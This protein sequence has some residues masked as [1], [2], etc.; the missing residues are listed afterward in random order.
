MT[1]DQK[2]REAAE[3]YISARKGLSKLAASVW[4]DGAKWG[5]REGFMRALDLLRS[6]ECDECFDTHGAHEP[7]NRD[8]AD[9]LE[10][11]WK[12]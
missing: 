1:P 7:D 6:K 8:I 2:R 10:Q 3:K 9:W 11:Q 5:E 12:E 4:E